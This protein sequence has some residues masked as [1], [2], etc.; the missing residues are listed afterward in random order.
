MV[1]SWA[2]L[3]QRTQV[4]LQE[5]TNRGVD[6]LESLLSAWQSDP[7]YLLSAYQSWLPASLH[8]QVAAMWPPV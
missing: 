2:R 7:R 3:Q 4:L 5:L 1:K 8:D 6:N